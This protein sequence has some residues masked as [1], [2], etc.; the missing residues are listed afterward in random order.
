MYFGGLIADHECPNTWRYSMSTTDDAGLGELF[1]AD[2]LATVREAARYLALSRTAIYELMASGRLP[3]CRLPGT[4]RRFSRRIPWSVLKE[5][6]AK[7][8]VDSDCIAEP[9]KRSRQE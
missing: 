1:P 3:H 5:F 9:A 2:R 6:V 7:S 4:G 8:M